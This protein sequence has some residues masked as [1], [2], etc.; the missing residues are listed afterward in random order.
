MMKRILLLAGTL[1]ACGPSEPV[2]ATTSTPPKDPGK[3]VTVDKTLADIGLDLSAIDKSVDPCEDFFTYAC[4]GWIKA[5]PIPAD[6]GK[7]GR[8]SELTQRNRED[9]KVILEGARDKPGDDPVLQK[10]GAFYGACMDETKIEAAGLKPLDGLLAK[11]RE[12]KDAKGVAAAI[13]ELERAGVEA[14]FGFNYEQDFKDAK[15]TVAWLDQAGLGLPDRDFYLEAD[16][17]ELLGPYREHVARTLELAGVP[18]AKA[19]ADKIVALE[20]ELAKISLRGADRRDPVRIFN[21]VDLSGLGEIAPAIPWDQYFAALG[22]PKVTNVAIT[23]KEFFAGMSKLI[24]T[25]PPAVWQAY[26][27]YHAVIDLAPTLPKRFVDER[28]T[29]DAMLTGKKANEERWKRCVAATDAALGD[30]V[31]QPWVKQ[32]FTPEAKAA[33]EE[34]VREIGD[35]FAR[36]VEKLDWMDPETKAKALTKRKATLVQIG[37]PETWLEYA[38]P[39]GEV[40]ADNV[41]AGRAAELRR[42]MS[43]VN[44]P[45]DRLEWGMSAPTVNAYYNAN[46]NKMVF[47]GGILQTPFYS[48]KATVPVNLGGMGMIV[49]HELTHGFDDEGSLFDGEGNMSGWWKPETR[50]AFEERTKCVVEQYGGYETIPGVKL[51][52]KLTAGENIADIAGVKLAFE[53]Y[54]KMRGDAKERVRADGYTEDQQFFLAVGQAWCSGQ[55]DAIAKTLAKTDPHSPGRWRVNGSLRNLPAFGEA[56]SCKPGTAM[57]PAK[58]CDVW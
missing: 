35:A 43:K 51:D 45:Q 46:L 44:Q 48:G 29:L 4:A 41:I 54:R 42:K 34:M 31:A 39:V 33:A 20:T 23:S 9:L 32:R 26:L 13:I 37:Y 38:F 53:A 8:G 57:R 14:P 56:W 18:D 47:P 24:Q 7:W 40:Y 36:R 21:R 52:G 5:N 27:T 11:V 19:A 55:R 17:T 50:T 1:A 58:P 49:G 22:N 12:A 28:F 15:Q 6:K 30:L 25:T 10:L 3:P 2:T 16:S